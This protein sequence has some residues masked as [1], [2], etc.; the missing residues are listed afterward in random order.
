MGGISGIGYESGHWQSGCW[1]LG[2]RGAGRG[3]AG[4]GAGCGVARPADPVS[5]SRR[6]T[7]PPYWERPPTRRSHAKRPADRTLIP[8]A[9]TARP[10]R[11]DGRLRNAGRLGRVPSSVTD[12]AGRPR[13]AGPRHRADS[14]RPSDT[15]CAHNPS[16]TT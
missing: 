3:G 11:A 4:R 1:L 12:G 15:E 8:P 13:P 7:A 14:S 10:G 2:S 9:V 5:P 6:R 16:Q